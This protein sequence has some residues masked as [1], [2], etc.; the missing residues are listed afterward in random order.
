[1][2]VLRVLGMVFGGFIGA[3][4]RD[5]DDRQQRKN[6]DKKTEA[7]EGATLR[8]DTSPRVAR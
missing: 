2:R 3:A 4:L 6:T 8:D 1:M 7:G 5:I